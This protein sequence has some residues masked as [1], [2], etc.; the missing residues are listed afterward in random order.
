MVDVVVIQRRSGD[1]GCAVIL[2]E[3]TVQNLTLL[4][5]GAA[6]LDGAVARSLYPQRRQLDTVIL[7]HQKVAD[8]EAVCAIA[9]CRAALLSF[10]LPGGDRRAL[11][12]LVPVL[13]GNDEVLLVDDAQ[14]DILLCLRQRAAHGGEPLKQRIPLG[15]E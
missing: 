6:E 14:G 4:H 2:S 3:R 15:V 8:V 9:N 7:V 11:D 1:I 5:A 12:G 13:E 10:A